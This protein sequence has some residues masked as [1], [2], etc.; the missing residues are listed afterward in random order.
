MMSTRTFRPNKAATLLIAVSFAVLSIAG[1]AAPP[2]VPDT[3][4]AAKIRAALRARYPDVEFKQIVP[5]P[6]PGLYELVTD[7]GI[8]YTDANGDYLFLGKILDAKTK[9]DLTEERWNALNTIEFDKLPL[10]LALKFVKGDGKRRVAVFEDPHCPFC[11]QL[12]G[13]LQKITNATIYVF[14][15]PI[16][17][18]HHGATETSKNIWCAKDREEA[19]KKAMLNNEKPPAANCKADALQS[20][21]KMGDKLGVNATPTLFFPNGRRHPGSMA[22]AALEKALSDNQT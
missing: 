6:M 7:S 4:A 15:Y 19:W 11:R 21:T 8:V 14:L 20:L 5:A 18:L 13:E 9:D 3:P 16:E 22:S 12:E 1:S 2:A 17:S 10:S